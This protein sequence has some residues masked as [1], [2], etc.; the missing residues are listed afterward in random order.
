MPQFRYTARRS[1]GQLAQGVVEANDRSGAVMLVEQQRCFPIKIELVA[2]AA[3][4]GAPAAKS[5][6]PANSRSHE[7]GPVNPSLA[8]SI[9]LAGQ[10]LFTEQLGHLLSAGMTLDEALGVLVRR[11]RQP[12]LQ[13]ISPTSLSSM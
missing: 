11:L 4:G 9:P 12:R 2:A 7:L 10:F 1:D 13:A 8:Q 3:A 5:A 6:S